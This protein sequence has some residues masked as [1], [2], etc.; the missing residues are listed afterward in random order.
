MEPV[1]IVAQRLALYSGRL[2]PSSVDY[3]QADD[4]VKDRSAAGRINLENCS[5]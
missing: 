4:V 2:K 1:E 3:T 5:S